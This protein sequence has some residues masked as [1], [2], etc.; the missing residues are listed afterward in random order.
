MRIVHFAN[1]PTP[2]NCSWDILVDRAE[3][4][5]EIAINRRDKLNAVCEQTAIEIV[6]QIEQAASRSSE[7]IE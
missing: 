1:H 7:Q 6:E 3:Q 4:W 5:L 2:R